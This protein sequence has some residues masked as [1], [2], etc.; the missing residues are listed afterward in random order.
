MLFSFSYM[1]T[2]ACPGYN[3]GIQYCLN[4]CRHACSTVQYWKCGGRH[5]H[6]CD[7]VGLL[8]I[9][10]YS[11]AGAGAG[12][13]ATSL[14]EE[15]GAVNLTDQSLSFDEFVSAFGDLFTD[16]GGGAEVSNSKAK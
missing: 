9:N 16:D 12:T 13:R 6:T 10:Y 2:Q 8:I 7:L 5:R 11:H 1:G 3:I 4:G 15:D 14:D